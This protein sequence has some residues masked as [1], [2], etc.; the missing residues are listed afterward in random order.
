MVL[1]RLR[2]RF[3]TGRPVWLAAST[4][5]GE[6]ALLLDAFAAMAPDVDV[7]LVL[8]PRHPQRFD[9]VA[10]LAAQRGF[11]MARRSAGAAVPAQARVLVGDS[12]GEMLAYYGAADVAILGGSFLPFGGQNLIEPCAMGCP[13]VMGPHTYNFEEAADGAIGAGAA[14]RVADAGAAL[15]AAASISADEGRRKEMGDKGRAFVAAHRGAVERLVEWI[16]AT[17]AAA[18]R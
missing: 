16:A 12:M 7:L 15:E 8:V 14:L 1:L 11:A 6:E 9:E 13:V 18:R 17:A 3:G 5:D 10:A 2:A 4:R